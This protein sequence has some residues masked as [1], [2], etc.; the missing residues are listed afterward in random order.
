MG[1][2]SFE[3]IS[4]LSR[5]FS[6]FTTE[7]NR[8][9]RYTIRRSISIIVCLKYFHRATEPSHGRGGGGG[10]YRTHA[11]VYRR[12][13]SDLETRRTSAAM[14]TRWMPLMSNRPYAQDQ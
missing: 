14:A 10:T 8:I 2:K 9:I 6:L 4:P 12:N 11:A 1:M 7:I 13:S 5:S 3:T